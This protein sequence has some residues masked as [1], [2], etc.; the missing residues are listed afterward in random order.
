MYLC[1]ISYI[2]AYVTYVEAVTGYSNNVNGIASGNIG[3]VNGIATA[4]ISKVNGI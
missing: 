3:K 4:D 2:Y 1:V